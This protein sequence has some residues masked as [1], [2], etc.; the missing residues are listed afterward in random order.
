MDNPLLEPATNTTLQNLLDLA[1]DAR[2]TC[3]LVDKVVLVRLN[4][5]AIIRIPKGCRKDLH[6]RH[7]EHSAAVVLGQRAGAGVF[8]TDGRN[9]LIQSRR[10][11]DLGASAGGRGTVSVTLEGQRSLTCVYEMKPCFFIQGRTSGPWTFSQWW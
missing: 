5:L 8:R 4:R 3:L 6:A 9:A 10:G 1:P 2:D 11:M 7:L